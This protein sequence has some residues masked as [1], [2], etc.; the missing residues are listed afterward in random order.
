[1]KK[2]IFTILALFIFTASYS[3]AQEIK[4]GKE[5]PIKSKKGDWS[6]ADKKL[7]R[8]AIT[9]VD[10][11]LDVLGE[12]KQP[13]IHCYLIKIEAH[14]KSFAKADKNFKGCEKLAEEC[15]HDLGL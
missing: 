12:L 5:T 10:A 4:E 9:A 2:G 1:M 13:F 8:V 11:D 6:A 14:Y 15:I 3:Q 7:A